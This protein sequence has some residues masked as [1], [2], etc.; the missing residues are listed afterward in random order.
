MLFFLFI[1]AMMSFFNW[2]LVAVIMTLYVGLK[3]KANSEGAFA[4]ISFD[5]KPITIFMGGNDDSVAR[6][7]KW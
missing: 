6:Q 4:A 3:Y 2:F 5:G 7:G 1:G